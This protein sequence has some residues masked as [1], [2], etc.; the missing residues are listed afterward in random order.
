MKRTEIIFILC[1]TMPLARLANVAHSAS[2]PE[3]RHLLEQATDVGEG[4]YGWSFY[5][6][7][8]LYR[9]IEFNESHGALQALLGRPE[10][11]VNCRNKDGLT[12]LHV[13]ALKNREGAVKL[14]MERRD[15][16]INATADFDLTPLHL[17]ARLG[18]TRVLKQLFND[19]S[20][21]FLHARTVHDFSALH[22]VAEGDEEF[23]GPYLN[24]RRACVE[25]RSMVVGLLRAE[26]EKRGL[27]GFEHFKDIFGRTAL[28]YAALNGFVEMVRELLEFS[29]LNP[30]TADSY[31]L[32]PL[33][34]AVKNGHV[35]VSCLIMQAHLIDLNCRSVLRHV[36]PQVV[37][38]HSCRSYMM[39]LLYPVLRDDETGSETTAIA[40]VTPVHMAA[41]GSHFEILSSLLNSK[42]VNLSAVDSRSL[43]ALHH[44]VVSG[45]A[46]VVKLLMDQPDMDL[47]CRDIEG[48]SP[49]Q[50]SVVHGRLDILKALLGDV[51]ATAH[52][53]ED[54]LHHS[55]RL[56]DIATRH[57]RDGHGAVAHYLIDCLEE[58]VKKSEGYSDST[59]A[60]WA[61][62]N[63]NLELTELILAWRPEAVN[64]TNKKRQ[65]PLHLA[66]IHR[67]ADLVLGLC[68]EQDWRL[69][70][71]ELDKMGATPL[72]YAFEQG[73]EAREIQKVLLRRA[74][75][76]EH[77]ERIYRLDM[78]TMN[79]LFVGAALFASVTYVA[80]MQPPLGFVEDYNFLLP[81]PPAP[82]D[83]YAV[84]ANTRNVH[85]KLFFIFNTISFVFSLV[86]IF[87]GIEA[88][89]ASRKQLDVGYVSRL[90]R[91]S[92]RQCY[93]YF[94]LSTSFI[95][96]AFEQAGHA[97]LAPGQLWY[98]PVILYSLWASWGVLALLYARKRI[99]RKIRRCCRAAGSKVKRIWSKQP[100]A[101]CNIS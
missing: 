17:A 29:Y 1:S 76:K 26:Q 48:M 74:D 65:T 89:A 99:K 46:R 61:C 47:N 82:Q 71:A 56:L 93:W 2:E 4:L 22:L 40:G 39:H 57:G 95:I 5:G 30:N 54:L 73:K 84:Y 34:L 83:T 60:H 28:H 62:Q 8:A 91:S 15:L 44:A 10:I 81:S 52:M 35:S 68:R 49:L 69:R 58:S 98:F 50:L 20:R 64:A 90:L 53:P 3:V 63:G 31:G 14:L 32:T 41:G 51:T 45:D 67:H 72:D 25:Q 42:C 59:L 97:V 101:D 96:A 33:H 36:R 16:D 85:V 88:L 38:L 86:T 79:A 18:H 23:S 55:M 100:A 66:V 6:V 43:T 78:N 11:D 80:W 27:I 24:S 92:I 7:Q 12:P 37:P 21:L 87:R 19:D 13:A 94:V 75:V 9:M 70:A 77:M